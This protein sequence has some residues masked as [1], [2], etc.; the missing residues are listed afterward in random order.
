[1]LEELADVEREYRAFA[2]GHVAPQA[3]LID[4]EERIPS[5]VIDA[6][7]DAK[8]FASG[9][10]SK[11]DD[12]VLA[13][14]RHGLLHEALGNASASVQ[15]LVNVHHMAGSAIARWGTRA[16]KEQWVPRLTSGEVLAALAITEPNVGSD[17]AAVETTA[18]PDGDSWLLR[19]TKRWIT[20]GQIADVFV[21]L[22]ATEHG[23]ATFLV[24]RKL[25]GLRIQPIRGPLGCRRY[26]L[27]KLHLD[28][29][30]L[31]SDH[32]LGKPG[33]GLTHVA[34]TRLDACLY[35]LACSCVGP[36]P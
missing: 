35:N 36:A 27:A 6:L 24:P 22:P 20:C 9:F 3:A 34:A 12:L 8:L 16:Q 25:D 21:L 32:L 1:M 10:P 15:G 14:L 29:C 7:R 18:T 19:G 26:I 5:S 4:R 30:R 31:P 33:F 28:G 23:P 2:D 13:N 11:D 17:A